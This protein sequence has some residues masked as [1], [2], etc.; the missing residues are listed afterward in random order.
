MRKSYCLS[1]TYKND[2]HEKRANQSRQ[3]LPD[4]DDLEVLLGQSP[5]L[6]QKR[7]CAGRARQRVLLSGLELCKSQRNV[8]ATVLL[9]PTLVLPLSRVI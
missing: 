2:W 6:A 1:G 5:C 3:K 8:Y 9:P 4:K 7:H